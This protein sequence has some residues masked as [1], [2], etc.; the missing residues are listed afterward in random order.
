VPIQYEVW[1]CPPRR[2]KRILKGTYS[3]EEWQRAE[4]YGRRLEIRGYR[5]VIV[6]EVVTPD[7]V[8]P[9]E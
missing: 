4:R 5:K 7:A 1:A 6:R 3:E 8:P 9:A 2:R